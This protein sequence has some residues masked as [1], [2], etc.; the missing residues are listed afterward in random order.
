MG[1]ELCAC[2]GEGGQI[3]NDT[4]SDSKL[5]Q[6]F[7]A[8]LKQGLQCTKISKDRPQTEIKI[9]LHEP[10][11]LKFSGVDKDVSGDPECADEQIS[12]MGIR[13]ATDPD[14][15]MAHFAG[16]QVLRDNLDPRQ[17][18]KA[19]ILEG[20][21]K[22]MINLVAKSDAEAQLMITGFKLLF[23]EARKE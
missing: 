1:N 13:Q 8:K 19:F 10:G 3:D 23:A 16:S 14:P 22:K 11:T 17:A 4:P 6:R 5:L 18:M 2:F 15:H 9:V 20:P 7:K 12:V 21:N